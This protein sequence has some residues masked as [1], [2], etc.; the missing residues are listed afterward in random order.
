MNYARNHIQACSVMHTSA[1]M[2][3]LFDQQVALLCT[4]V[5]R[6]AI[7]TLHCLGASKVVML[8]Q[9]TSMHD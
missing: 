5:I 6:I 9:L 7:L 1:T 2:E 8:V 4:F 3:S